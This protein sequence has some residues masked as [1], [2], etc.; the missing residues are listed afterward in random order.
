[1]PEHQRPPLPRLVDLTALSPVERIALAD[2]LYDSA[3]SELEAA[4]AASPE[5]AAEVD[6]QLA[7]VATGH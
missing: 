2:V 4:A 6:G 7:R 1:M 5:A 3:M